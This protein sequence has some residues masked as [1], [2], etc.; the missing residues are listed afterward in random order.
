MKYHCSKCGLAVI[1]IGE[2]ILKPCQCEASI[3]AEMSGEAKG[4][5]GI[6]TK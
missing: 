4:V 2:K 6:K 1:I 3:V 5:G